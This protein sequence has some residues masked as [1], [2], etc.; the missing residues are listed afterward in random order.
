[1]VDKFEHRNDCGARRFRW[2]L[3]PAVRDLYS[4]IIDVSRE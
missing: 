1:V 3:S 4:R 2:R